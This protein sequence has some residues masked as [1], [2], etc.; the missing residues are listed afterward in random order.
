[1][2][3]ETVLGF[4]G[5]GVYHVMGQER[6]CEL[7]RMLRVGCCKFPNTKDTSLMSIEE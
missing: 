2:E 1:M 7:Q 6:A 3:N 5:F 4:N